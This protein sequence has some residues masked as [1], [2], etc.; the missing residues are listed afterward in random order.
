MSLQNS[1]EMLLPFDIIDEGKGVFCCQ[2]V[3]VDSGKH[4][5]TVSFDDVPVKNSPFTV[6]VGTVGDASKCFIEGREVF[7]N[8]GN[9]K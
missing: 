4:C 9:V 2:Y 5:V 8:G 1:E 3:P 6:N 7:M